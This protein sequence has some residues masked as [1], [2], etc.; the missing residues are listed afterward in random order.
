MTEKWMRSPR[1][2]VLGVATGLAEWR[3]LPAEPVRLIVFFLILFTGF[4][5]GALIYLALALVLPAQQEGDYQ[6]GERAKA[7]KYSHVYRDA[8]DV[9]YEEASKST[10]ELKEEYERLKRKVEAMESEMFDKEKEWDEKFNSSTR[11]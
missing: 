1:G 8:Q 10:E 5:P 9:H 4:F 2:K 7:W 6:P 11:E 3:D